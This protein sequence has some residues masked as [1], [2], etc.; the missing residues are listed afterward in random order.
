M[1]IIGK[2]CVYMI[3][4]S[5]GLDQV[6]DIWLAKKVRLHFFLFV[7]DSHNM[8]LISSIMYHVMIVCVCVSGLSGR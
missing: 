4:I 2:T 3:K 1:N 6:D 8:V 5:D 7:K